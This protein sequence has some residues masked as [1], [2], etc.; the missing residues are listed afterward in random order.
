MLG[1]RPGH[2]RIRDL[3]AKTKADRELA[4]IEVAQLRECHREARGIPFTENFLR[5]SILELPAALEQVGF[6]LIAITVLV[7]IGETLTHD[8]S[9]R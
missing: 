2:S 8:H 5:D 1:A 9:R 6:S 7:G 3:F 4:E